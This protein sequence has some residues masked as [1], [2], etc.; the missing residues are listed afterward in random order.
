MPPGGPPGALGGL[1]SQREFYHRTDYR[2]IRLK[3]SAQNQC[4]DC[5]QEGFGWGMSTDMIMTTQKEIPQV[6]IRFEDK[7]A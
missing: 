2:L 7:L 4:L 1:P 5:T 3:I 6:K